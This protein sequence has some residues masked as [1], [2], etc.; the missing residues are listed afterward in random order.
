VASGVKGNPGNYNAVDS[1]NYAVWDEQTVLTL[2]NVPW[3]NDYRDIVQ[4][5]STTN[6]DTWIDAQP[7][8]TIRNMSLLKF[9]RN[10]RVNL[11]LNAAMRY[12]YLRASN[13]S[14]PV[15]GDFA[16][17]Y[18]YFISDVNYLAPDTTELTLQLDVWQSF[19]YDVHFGS[20]FVERG[21]IG[22]ANTNYSAGYGR[23]YLSVP[24]GFDL[25]GEYRTVHVKSQK[26]MDNPSVGTNY[27]ILVVSTV[28]L[29][30]DSGNFGSATNPQIVA[31]RGSHFMGLPSG[32][33][34]Y[35]LKDI[36]GLINFMSYYQGKPWITQ[37]ILSMTLI[38]KV[39][40]Y[41]GNNDSFLVNISPSGAPYVFEIAD[42]ASTRVDTQMMPGWRLNGAFINNILG[43]RYQKLRKFL[44][45]PYMVIELTSWTGSPL[46]IKPEMWQ[47]P[48][49][50]VS[51][52][53]T[54]FP[55]GQ[56]VAITPRKYNSDA[57]TST[58]SENTADMM[59]NDDGGEYLDFATIL[60]NFPQIPIVNDM[61]VAYIANNL[62][63]LAFQQQS[64]DWSQ[65][66]AL[67]GNQVGYNQ[68]SAGMNLM[69]SLTGIQT[70]AAS[71]TA[72]LQSD[73]AGRS[74]AISAITGIAGGAFNGAS[75]GGPG[76]A[77]AGGMGGAIGG[78]GAL[79]HAAL[80]QQGITEGTA[81][82]NAARNASTG[83][84][85]GTAGYMRDT[86]KNLADWAA[87]GDYANAIAGINAKVQD[88][89]MTQPSVG[90]QYG[91]EALNISNDNVGFSLRWKML[92][93][94][95]MR[96]IGD[97]WLRYG[98]AIEQFIPMPT[99]L[100]VMSKFTYWKLTETYISQAPIPESFKQIIRGIFEKGVTVWADPSYIGVTDWADNTALPNIS[101]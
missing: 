53:A 19:G 88:S 10:V 38:P 101:Y 77:V 80:Q 61:S 90:G 2:V 15:S 4:F 70:G 79:G 35:I 26:I 86:N 14:L 6:L 30:Q 56:R 32:A 62:H 7:N 64:A 94:N 20:C 18:Y 67:A 95:A 37:G 34:L 9:K 71:A 58:I 50:T 21:H 3:N 51:E 60:E 11:P 82:S 22:I 1:F 40:R 99:N 47:D 98:Y 76:G 66:K 91:G 65:N 12:N 44:T 28:D 42:A 55:T 68:A 24:E 63:S 46:V 23:D 93:L 39:T 31:A 73:L 78:I 52:I 8:V 81:I 54:F 74:G 27:N 25:G 59:N 89:H 49:A 57:E 45:Y 75:E 43:P 36:Q 17:N 97:F 96:K 41:L 33:N 16:R 72:A 92:N 69:S 100:M 83:A 29:A 13:P 5:G 85:V 87:K 84:Q 48:D